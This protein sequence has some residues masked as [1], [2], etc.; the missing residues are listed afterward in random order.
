M[1]MRHALTCT[2]VAGMIVGAGLLAGCSHEQPAGSR[3]MLRLDS[4]AVDLVAGTATEHDEARLLARA[5]NELIRRCMAAQGQPYATELPR[6]ESATDA[7]TRPDLAS[8][9]SVGYGLAAAYARTGGEDPLRAALPPGRQAGYDQA[10]SGAGTRQRSVTIDGTTLGYDTDG[11]IATSRADLYG[12]LDRQAVLILVQQKARLRID[13]AVRDD[14]RYRA[15]VTAWSGCMTATGHRFATP[16]DARSRL[17]EQFAQH[18]AGTALRQTEVAVAVADAKCAADS[19]LVSAAAEVARDFLSRLP[20]EI[21]QHL[22]DAVDTRR[23]AL[24]R[25]AAL[26]LPAQCTPAACHG[27][28]THRQ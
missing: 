15:A 3:T 7:V 16:D 1:L 13:V 19:G 4:A 14:R 11:C 25:A 28:D 12:N 20:D 27:A 21:L 17:S 22:P 26:A 9:R 6:T 10:L 24:D 2:L 18:G 5:E 23:V 8:R